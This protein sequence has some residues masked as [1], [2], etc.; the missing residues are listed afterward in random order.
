M[1]MVGACLTSCS[2]RDETKVTPEAASLVQQGVLPSQPERAPSVDSV[3]PD[4]ARPEPAGGGTGGAG[5]A[6]GTRPVDPALPEA[7]SDI[8]D[9]GPDARQAPCGGDCD[10]GDPDAGPPVILPPRDVEDAGVADASASADGGTSSFCEPGELRCEGSRIARCSAELGAF[11]HASDCGVRSACESLAARCSGASCSTEELDCRPPNPLPVV[12]D[13]QQVAVGEEFTCVLLGSGDVRCWGDNSHG[14]LGLGAVDL[15]GSIH[16]PALSRN[17]VLGG[18]ALQVVAGDEHACALLANGSVRCWGEC[19][20]GRLGYVLGFDEEDRDVGDDETPALMGDVALGGP[21]IQLSAGGAVTCALLANG[22]VRCFG[23]GTGGKLGILTSSLTESVGDDEAPASVSPIEL[24]GPTAFIAS[25]HDHSC[26]ISRAGQVRCW[27]RGGQGRLGYGKRV[28][29]GLE[30]IGDDETPASVGPVAL[31]ERAVD[32]SLGNAHTCAVFSDGGAKC[33]GSNARYQAGQPDEVD[34][35]DQLPAAVPRLSVA[36]GVVQVAAGANHS[37]LLLVGGSLRCF[38]SNSHGQ[39][40]TP[41]RSGK[42]SLAEAAPYVPVGRSVLAV[43]A[44]AETTCAV[45]D[46]RELSC[47]GSGESGNLGYA[48]RVN[49]GDTETPASVGPISIY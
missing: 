42:V 17:V 1:V 22:D 47:W 12:S 40:G 9:A 30:D 23:S 27:G 45:L 48:D 7:G 16:T 6:P 15:R 10:P 34:T 4:V 36:E 8:V 49:V 20:D 14:Q 3:G 26:A 19:E 37:C 44:T 25:G 46:S 5:G 13:V 35:V 21:V 33:W 43:G 28:Q 29:R 38:G 18:P 32:L 2:G 11:E 24:G 39:L 41:P 31:P